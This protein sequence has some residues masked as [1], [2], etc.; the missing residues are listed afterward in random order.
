M[1]KYDFDTVIDRHN[2]NCLKYD[3][4]LKRM[5]R[6]D[7][8]PMWVADMDFSLPSEILERI[9]ARTDH[10]IFGYTEPSDSYYAV[11]K[12][13]H[14]K[15]YGTDFE[16]SYNTITPGV[17]FAI[18]AAIRAFTDKGDKVLINEPV[19]YPFRETIEDNGRTVVS[20]NLYEKSG[21]YE[22][23][24]DDFEKKAA[25]P[26]VKLFV[27]CNPHNPVGRVYT[28]E[29]L[30]KI[31]DICLKNNVIVVSD[32]IHCDFIYKGETFNSYAS[33][34]QKYLDNGIICTSP[35]KTFNLAGLQVANIQIP[36]KTLRLLF[37]KEKAAAGYSQGNTLGLTAT[38]AAY[39][40]GEEYL[41]ELKEYL[42]GNL[43]FMDKFIREEIPGLRLIKPEGTYL[44]WVDFSGVASTEKEMRS[45]V[46][47]GARLWLDEGGIFGKGYELFERFNIACT[48]AFLRKALEQL[49]DAVNAAK[50]V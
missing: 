46:V 10:G 30:T 5:G 13:W 49:R 12:R 37:R 24:F 22:I 6:S 3:Y 43:E 34:E 23:D 35:G 25:D 2:T 29:E 26:S 36:D 9:K 11:L 38:E 48:R 42:R 21:H 8:M 14:K 39:E 15:H 20:S 19:Y 44:V 27:L 16:E 17:V 41:E 40:L 7:L 33:L 45:I 18:A 32:E 50:G 31:A 1:G 47:D 4:G 28:K